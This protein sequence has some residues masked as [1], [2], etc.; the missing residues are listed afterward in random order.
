ME[1]IYLTS[2]ELAEYPVE[3]FIGKWTFNNKTCGTG[4]S[5]KIYEII[6]YGIAHEMNMMICLPTH[7]NIE[8]FMSRMTVH[9]DQAIELW[10][11]TAYCQLRNGAN[12]YLIGCKNCTHKTSCLYIRQFTIAKEKPVIFIVPHHLHLVQEYDPDILIID[13]SIEKLAHKGIKVPER[14]QPQARLERVNCN[15]CICR[16]KCSDWRKEY[17]GQR[18]CYFTLY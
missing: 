12:A 18:G 3:K 2:E 11:K 9:R 5:R 15:T 17:R 14:L 13:E 10:G 1:E 4:K 7:D 16:S 8:E 6:E